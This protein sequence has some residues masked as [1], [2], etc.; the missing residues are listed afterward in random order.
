MNEPRIFQPKVSRHA[1]RMPYAG[2]GIKAKP[3]DAQINTASHEAAK[4]KIKP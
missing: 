4:D 1:R 2:F 3:G